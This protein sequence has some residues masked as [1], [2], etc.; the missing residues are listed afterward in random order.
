ML[1]PSIAINQ[2]EFNSKP[3]TKNTALADRDNHPHDAYLMLGLDEI[4]FNSRGSNDLW[5]EDCHFRPHSPRPHHRRQTAKQI[6]ASRQGSDDE[7][8]VSEIWKETYKDLV[9]EGQGD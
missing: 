3:P 9:N 6:P 5:V 2:T 1:F 4:R 7:S 8:D